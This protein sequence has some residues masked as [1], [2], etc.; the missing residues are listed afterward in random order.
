MNKNIEKKY[1]DLVNY[2]YNKNLKKD[3]YLITGGS[4]FIGSYLANLLLHIHKSEIYILDI[5]TLQF[6]VKKNSFKKIDILNEKKL[7]KTIN[8]IN[9][10]YVIHL[11]AR[12]DLDGQNLQA[13]DTNTL[14]VKN[15]IK[16]LNSSNS[17]KRIIFTSS[18]LFEKDGYQQKH[19]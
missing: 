15:L 1:I 11:A 16:A 17:I 7:I 12:T 4:G 10:D 18:V 3:K 2:I 19:V 9:P 6:V 14:G 8:L 13:Y 5:K